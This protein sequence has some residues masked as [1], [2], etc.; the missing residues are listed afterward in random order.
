MPS[1]SARTLPLAAILLLGGCDS[2]LSITQTVGPDGARFELAGGVVLDIPAGAL[3]SEVELTAELITDLA[4]GGY[5]G[6]PD[7]VTGSPQVAIALTPHGTAF[8]IPATL[9]L[10]APEEISDILI[11]RAGD[12]SDSD[13]TSMGPVSFADGSATLEIDGFSAYALVKA[14]SCPCFDGDDVRAFHERGAYETS[15]QGAEAFWQDSG[16]MTTA[17]YSV[18]IGTT[19]PFLA[20]LRAQY[21]E[22][23]GGAATG[24]C[25]AGKN[26][27]DGALGSKWSDWFDFEVSPNSQNLRYASVD[28]RGFET[29]RALL[30]VGERGAAGREIG[31]VVTGLP[32]GSTVTLALDGAPFEVSAND[33]VTFAPSIITD[34]STYALTV[35]TQPAGATCTLGS[36]ATGT[37]AGANVLVDVTCA[38]GESCNGV[39][40]DADG[41]ID[42]GFDM[43]ADGF[44]TC[45]ADGTVGTADD[46]CDDA[47]ASSYPGATER[48]DGADNNCDGSVSPGESADADGDTVPDDCDTSSATCPYF[49]LTEVEDALALTGAECV[50]DATGAAI[51]E[52]LRTTYD[53]ATGVYVDYG[54][55]AYEYAGVLGLGGG[56]LLVSAVG[57]DE[58]NATVAH[59][60]DKART[61]I[62]FQSGLT[63]EEYDACADFV[64]YACP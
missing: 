31:T 33:T 8:N 40:D 18:K 19:V 7:F 17:Q 56:S 58:S 39:D 44:T 24:S 6:L 34:G 62:S 25:S 57:C 46:D 49:G 10:P 59:C 28:R 4:E 55:G 48:C 16:D 32:T 29:C 63:P 51:P 50:I 54:D 13:W 11:V 14:G 53:A 12:E 37:M 5:E 64:S 1:P 22:P 2:A 61:T 3:D 35:T 27:I 47:A 45:G 36:N 30:R 15:V 42:E 20:S 23:G 41:S 60:T 52:P 26:G 21:R 43:D 9:T 38:A